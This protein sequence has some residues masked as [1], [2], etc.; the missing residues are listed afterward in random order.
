MITIRT[1]TEANTKVELKKSRVTPN[2]RSQDKSNFEILK[3]M[4][5]PILLYLPNITTS[6]YEQHRFH[7]EISATN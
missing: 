2:N 7:D 4:L 6:L 3:L 1:K 5:V